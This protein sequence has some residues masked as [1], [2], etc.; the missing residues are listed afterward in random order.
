MSYYQP[1][2]DCLH[3]PEEAR[4]KLMSSSLSLLGRTKRCDTTIKVCSICTQS[5]RS[6]KKNDIFCYLQSRQNPDLALEDICHIWKDIIAKKFISF[7]K[8]KNGLLCLPKVNLIAATSVFGTIEQNNSYQRAC[9]KLLRLS[10]T[11]HSNITFSCLPF[12]GTSSALFSPT[13]QRNK[14][15]GLFNIRSKS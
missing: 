12:E 15:A 9:T 7:K 14:I 2:Y 6:S 1:L 8:V 11:N 13:G 4:P 3:P 10:Q 5:S